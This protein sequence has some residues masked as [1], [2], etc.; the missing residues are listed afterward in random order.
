MSTPLYWPGKYF[1]YPIGNT[2]AVSFTRDL[3]PRTPAN[4]LLLG[5]GDPRSVLFTVYNEHDGS[6]RRLDITCSDIDPAI[7]ARN[8][9]LLTMI[10]DNRNPSSTIWKIFF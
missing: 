2:P 9:L 1:F 8:I 5:C 10:V 6:D 3:S 4:I 7:I